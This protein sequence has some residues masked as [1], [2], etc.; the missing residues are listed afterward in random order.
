M[1]VLKIQKPKTTLWVDPWLSGKGI[2]TFWSSQNFT[3]YFRQTSAFPSA[4]SKDFLAQ[5]RNWQ[6]NLDTMHIEP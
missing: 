4:D 3:Q 1:V 5:K 2:E 6:T